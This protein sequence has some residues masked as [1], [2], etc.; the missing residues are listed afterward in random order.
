MANE[1]SHKSVGTQL[2]QAEFEAVG[3]HVLDSQAAGDIIYASSTSQ[4]SRLGIG[5]AGQLLHTN[6]GASAPEWTAALTGAT[7]IYN[8]SLAIGYG[9]SH[10]NIDFS[11]DNAIILD[12]DGTQQIK[13]VDGV[14]QPI[15]D[16][17]IDLGTSVLEFKDA[18]FDGTVTTDG[19]TVSGTTNLDGA[20]Q[21]DNTI[22][23]GVDDTGYDIKFFGATAGSFLLWDESDDALELTDSSPIKIGDGGDMQ[24]YHDGSNSYITNSTGALKIATES[25]GIAVTIGHG[26]SEVTIADNL[27]VTGTF[28]LGS[29]AELTEAE[30]EMLDGITAGTAAASKAVVLD[31]NKDIATLRNLTIDGVF[32]DGNYTFD[33]SGNVSGLGT[34]G[35]GAITSTGSSSFA[36]AVK[37]PKIQYTDAD[38][39]MTI[40]DGGGVTFAAGL[41]STAA[42]NT[43]GATSFNDGNITNVGDIDVDTISADSNDIGIVLTDNRATALEIKESSNTYMTFVTTNSSEKIQVGADDAGYDV[44]FYGDTASANMTWDTSVDDLILNGAARIVIPDSQLVLGSTAVTTTGSEINLI[45]GGTARGTTS[46]ASGDGILINDA[47][48]MRMTNVDTVSTYFASHS[49]GGTSIVTV[50]TIGTGTWQGDA[51]ASGYIAADAIT[52]AKIDDDAINSEHYTD[53]SIDT[54]HIADNQVTLAKMAGL[55]RGKIIYGDASGDPAAL[56]VGSA[57]YVLTSDGTDISWATTQSPSGAQT[58]ITTILNDGVKVGRDAHNLIDFTTDDAVTFR[59]ANVDEITLA[60]NE[61][62][63]TTSDG[64]ALG[65]TS[66]MWSDAFLASGGVLNFNNGDMTVT[67]SSNTLTV[68]GGTLATAALTASGIVKTDD[69]T[70]ATS[71]TDGSLQTDGGLSVALDGIF[72]DDVTLI[73]DAAVLNLGVDS[74]VSITHDGTSGGT[75]SG[76]PL[77]ID[78]LGASALANDTY[79]GI[80]LGFIAQ[81]TIAIGNAVYVHTA[82]GRV[83]PAQADAVGE[84]PCIGVAVTG[85]S[86]GGAVKILT[87]GI[88]NDSDGFGGALTEGAIMYVD[89]DTAGLVTATIPD[90]DSEFVQRVGIAVGPRDVFV[91]PSL[92]VIERD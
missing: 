28:T 57:N 60:A 15:T 46:V 78:S 9:S 70:N 52:G 36:T 8:S 65:T 33:T 2:T 35:S 82:D 56:T 68:A 69:T 58:G 18:Y 40:A 21:V 32:T 76:T 42:S 11:T 62:S 63:P 16:N 45:D 29:S 44:I 24:I 13:L 1:L 75:F 77:V 51:I 73:T 22:T 50:G 92:D 39:S 74:D 10:A 66:K 48:T 38:D 7:S 27:T 41:T 17:D 85:A 55:V 3:G 61:F 25:S 64:I 47:G 30:L 87:H 26:T 19:L 71:T 91:N 72:G 6:S 54:A 34:V 79:T 5:T 20:I 59:V 67:H 86:D 53:G 23:V 43:L 81:G 90:A 12:I 83:A 4:L 37:T 49:V 80:V 14:L 89:D 31:S 88:Y 84:M